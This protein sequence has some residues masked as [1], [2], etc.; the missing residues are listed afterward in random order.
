MHIL[1]QLPIKNSDTDTDNAKG[2]ATHA[3]ESV[4]VFVGDVYHELVGA[5]RHRNRSNRRQRDAPFALET[6]GHQVVDR[7]VGDE[8]GAILLFVASIYLL[9]GKHTTKEEYTDRHE[10]LRW[11]GAVQRQRSCSA[12]NWTR[13]CQIRTIFVIRKAEQIKSATGMPCP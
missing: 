5:L 4:V 8:Q 11:D 3:L 6:G 2:N 12:R 10:C 1:G 13:V 7:L 9:A